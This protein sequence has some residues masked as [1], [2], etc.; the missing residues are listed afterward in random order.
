MVQQETFWALVKRVEVLEKRVEVLE[1]KAVSEAPTEP[2]NSLEADKAT[3][4]ASDDLVDA[5]E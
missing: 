4:S 3:E 5:G 1:K 2:E